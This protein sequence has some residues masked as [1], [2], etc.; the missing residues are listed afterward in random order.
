MAGPL[1]GYRV[2]EAT[3]TVSGPMAAM[4][5]A[6]Q[7]AEVIKIEPPATGDPGRYLGSSRGGMAAL[8]AVLNRNKKSLPLDLKDPR[9]LEIFKNLVKTADVFLENYRPNVVEKLG[10]DYSELRKLN[11]GLVY[12][13]ISG[14]GQSGPYQNRK[15]FDPSIQATTGVSHDQ[16]RERP[17]NI[18]TII[19]DKVTA[20]TTAQA[21]TAALLEKAK[22]GVGQ[23]LPI[24][25]LDSALQYTWPDLMWS[26]TLL[27]DGVDHMGE[28]GDWFPIFKAKDGYVSIVL[29]RD[30]LFE[31]V[32]VWCGND[33]HTD[34]RFATFEARRQN[35]P[36]LTAAL[37]DMLANKTTEEIC[38][39]LDA[40]G[41]PVARVNSFDDIPS[42]PQVRH[43]GTLIETTHPQIGEMRYPR[44]PMRFD[45]ETPFPRSHAPFLGD[46][47]RD[48]LTEMGVDENEIKR[49]EARD[50]EC[51]EARQK[52]SA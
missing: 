4:V 12:A 27:G 31:L 42:D 6:D 17:E 5:L 3:T 14:Y 21:I 46:H 2:L 1:S 8:F 7:G 20:L 43:Q 44:P 39:N 30:D 37:D 26:R 23:Y 41:I 9:E 10:I 36:A 49:L 11:P 19:F 52:A 50:A 51:A 38:E 15:V 29:V 35:G 25:M 33:S 32:C 47:T 40:F 28:I 22:T 13:S 18:R 48:I 24:S 16:G 45:P 34:P